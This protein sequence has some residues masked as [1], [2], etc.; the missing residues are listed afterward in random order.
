MV[1]TTNPNALAWA[2]NNIEG[3][4]TREGVITAFPGGFPTQAQVDAWEAEY[5]A[6]IADGSHTENPELTPEDIERILL[7]LPGVSAATITQ[8]KRDRGKPL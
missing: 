2:N 6:A 3:I 8:A 4:E 1:L 7:G 5:N